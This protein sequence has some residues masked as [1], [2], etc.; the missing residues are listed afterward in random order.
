MG[1]AYIEG[2]K[3]KYEDT[4]LQQEEFLIS[5][6][7][8]IKIIEP[9]PEAGELKISSFII[10]IVSGVLLLA[11]AVFFYIRYHMRKKEEQARAQAEVK[12]TVEEKYLRLLKETIHFNTDNIKDSLADLSHLLNGYLSERYGTYCR[13][14]QFDIKKRRNYRDSGRIW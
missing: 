7:I 14:Y 4:I 5:E 8:G 11:I 10:F 9:L 2:I 1:M 13:R 3:I 6:R 12:E